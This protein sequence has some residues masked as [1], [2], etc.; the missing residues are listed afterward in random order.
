MPRY[1]FLSNETHADISVTD[2]Y[3]TDCGNN[4][5][6]MPVSVA[7]LAPLIANYPVF[8]SRDEETGAYVMTAILGFFEGENLF[9]DGKTWDAPYQ[10]L[11]AQIGPFSVVET[12]SGPNPELAIRIDMDDPRVSEQGGQALFLADGNQAEYLKRKS[13]IIAT[14]IKDLNAT[15]AFVAACHAHDLLEPVEL[16]VSF[17]DRSTV[18]FDGLLTINHEKLSALSGEALETFH[19]AGHL[20]AAYYITASLGQVQNLIRRRNARL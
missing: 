10:P 12:G 7:E 18:R 8:L 20:R 3:G 16:Q 13:A 4:V 6:M 5:H 19:A 17:K 1:E 14:I 9:L 15:D 2:R 11:Q